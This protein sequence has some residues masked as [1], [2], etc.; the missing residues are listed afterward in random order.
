MRIARI[1][2]VL[3]LG[4]MLISSFACGGDEAPTPTPTPTGT[5]TPLPT[6]TMSCEQALAAI[7]QA[8]DAYN[9]EHGDWPTTDG[10]PGDIEWS[11]LVPDFMAGIPSNDSKCEWQVNSDPEGEVCL[12]NIC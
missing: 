3:L 11:K 2:A 12:R 5:P 8:L 7:Q 10:Q 6:V 4:I 1:A 9:A